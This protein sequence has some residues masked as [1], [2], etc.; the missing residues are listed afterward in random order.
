MFVLVVTV[1]KELAD[2][3]AV[4]LGNSHHRLRLLKLAVFSA[5]LRKSVA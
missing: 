3:R 4:L 2:D 5:R 1:K